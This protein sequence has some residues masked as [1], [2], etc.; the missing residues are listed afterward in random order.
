ML[1]RLR[2]LERA[3]QRSP[4]VGA[5][6]V[7]RRLRS[8]HLAQREDR[9]KCVVDAPGVRKSVHQIRIEHEDI[10][11]AACILAA[12]SLAEVDFRNHSERC[13]A[14]FGMT[15]PRSHGALRNPGVH[16]RSLSAH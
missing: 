12:N 5:P 11:E 2:T 3:T 9:P 10:L 8:C 16:V 7:S 1:D 14:W 13:S 6:L 4:A 15:N